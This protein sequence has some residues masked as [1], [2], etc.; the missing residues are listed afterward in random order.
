MS[1]FTCSNCNATNGIAFRSSRIS[2]ECLKCRTYDGHQTRRICYECGKSGH[3]ASKCSEKVWKLQEAYDEVCEWRLYEQE[4]ADRAM[5]QVL[6]EDRD[7][8]KIE[9]EKRKSKSRKYNH[10]GI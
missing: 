3:S 10:R 8:T 6:K 1:T 4:M 9:R 5:H 2:N 7:M